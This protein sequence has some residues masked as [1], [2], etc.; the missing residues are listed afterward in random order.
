MSADV[1]VYI[2]AQPPRARAALRRLR[3]AIRAAAPEAEE[4][5]A[6][7]MPAFRSHGRRLV[8]F[9]A[10]KDHYSLF[11]A[12]STLLA[13]MRKDVRPYQAAVGTLRFEYGAPLPVGL[14]RRIVRARLT[15]NRA[16]AGGARP[17]SAR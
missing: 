14:V 13:T 10:F 16:K 3:Q 8:Y 12:S 11:P 9:A 5:I 2:A 7:R 15:E 17:Y 1:D 6:Y 4:V